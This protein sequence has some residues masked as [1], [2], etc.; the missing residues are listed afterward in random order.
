LDWYEDWLEKFMMGEVD[1]PFFQLRNRRPL[2]RTYVAN[3]LWHG[4]LSSVTLVS[5][6][7]FWDV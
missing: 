3:L 5:F 7:D 6:V 2:W 1:L 4:D